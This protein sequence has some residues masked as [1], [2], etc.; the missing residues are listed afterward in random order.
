MK[1]FVWQEYARSLPHS[2]VCVCAFVL[3]QFVVLCVEMSSS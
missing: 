2:V 1:D 3:V